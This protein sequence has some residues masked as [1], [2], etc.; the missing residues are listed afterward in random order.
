MSFEAV[1]VGLLCA[2]FIL[3][4]FTNNQINGKHFKK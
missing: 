1:I 4:H 3:T 2:A